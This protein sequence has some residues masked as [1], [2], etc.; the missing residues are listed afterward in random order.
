MS[1][2]V[3]ADVFPAALGRNIKCEVCLRQPP[4]VD[5]M[6]FMLTIPWSERSKRYVQTRGITTCGSISCLSVA[7][8]IV[9]IRE[10]D[11]R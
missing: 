10:A 8:Q 6:R 5:I 4:N 11:L 9:A 1:Q 2:T 7:Q 3:D